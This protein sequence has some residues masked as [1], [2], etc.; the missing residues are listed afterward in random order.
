MSDIPDDVKD[1][2]RQVRADRG[3]SWED[4]AQQFE[5]DGNQ[6]VNSSVIR[7]PNAHRALAAWAR[8]EAATE[9]AAP[10]PAESKPPKRDARQQPP[11]RT[12]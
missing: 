8:S 11:A 2:Y 3:C 10:Q 7:D 6:Q 4:M 9:T 1:N 5:R 12:A